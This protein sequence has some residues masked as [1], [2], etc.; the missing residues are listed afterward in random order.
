MI[1]LGTLANVFG[2]LLGGGLGLI[3]GN[4]LPERVQD[5]VMKATGVAVLFLGIAG[6]LEGILVLQDGKLVSQA[7]MLIILSLALG[8]LIGEVLNI[9]QGFEHFGQW[10]KRVSKSQGDGQFVDAFVTTSLTICIGAMAVVGSLQDG[11]LGDSST[12]LAKA[13]LDAIVV[14]IL[15]VS[16]GRGAIF[17]AVPVLLFQGSLTFL[18]T[19]IAPFV[20]ATMLANLSLV[21]SILIFCVGVNLIWGP[22][23]KVANLLPAILVALVATL[24]PFF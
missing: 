8:A 1:G 22:M 15:T 5:T 7:G 12:L 4:H 16:K 18:A 11:M 24:L 13:V 23:I 17:A 6:A 10:L 19:L 14:L 3:L 20:T 21:G 2:V 9:E